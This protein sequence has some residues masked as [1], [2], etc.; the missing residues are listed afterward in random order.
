[1]GSIYLW[2]SYFAKCPELA[3]LCTNWNESLIP[4]LTKK[5]M[6]Y[7]TYLYIWMCCAIWNYILD[8]PRI[9]HYRSQMWVMPFILLNSLVTAVMFVS[10]CI[11]SV[12]FRELCDS[13]T[14]DKPYQYY[15]RSVGQPTG[16]W[17]YIYMYIFLIIKRCIHTLKKTTFL[18][19]GRVHNALLFRNIDTCNVK[20]RWFNNEFYT[21]KYFWAEVYILNNLLFNKDMY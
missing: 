18:H 4:L 16:T 15:S 3:I 2:K 12:G 14:Q 19:V 7:Q 10:S 21:C 6:F 5:P 11:V 17:R 20:C 13:L 9:L 8:S 1:M